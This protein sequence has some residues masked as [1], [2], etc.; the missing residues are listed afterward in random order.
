MRP[1]EG[2]RVLDFSRHFAGA[3]GSRIL[4]NFGAEVL[5]VEWPEPPGLDFLRHMGPADG[6]EGI[7]RSGMFNDINV[8]KRSMTLNMG[9]AEGRDIA[10]ELVKISNVIFESMT[11]GVMKAW[12]LDYETVRQLRPDIVYVSCSGFGQTGPKANWR[13]YGI[14]SAAHAG[15]AHLA[16]LP[17]R[18]PAG[19][20]FQIGD[21]YAMMNAAM[22]LMAG[23]HYQRETGKSVFIDAPQT[24]GVITT[25]NQFVLDN[26]VNGTKTRRPD[27]P[28]GNKRLHP[29]VAPHDAFPCLGTDTWCVIAVYT[30]KEW[31]GLKVA[32]GNP[33]WAE[34]STY[35]TA[36]GRHENQGSLDE[37]LAGWTRGIERHALARL[38]QSH[39]VRAG[40]VQTV[41]DRLNW[42]RQ[43]EH[44]GTYAIFEHP[45]TGP[46]RHETVAAK[47]SKTPYEMRAAAPQ[48]GQDNDYVF[49]GLLKMSDD[50]IE[51]LK[52][53]DVIR[54]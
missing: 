35:R 42:D 50:D 49:R 47:L 24:Q 46:R 54:M 32:M 22:W 11:P 9:T 31:A 39:G 26:S 13:S 23:I 10:R 3:G 18:P 37:Q 38:L 27:F 1:L 15:T 29:Q 16:G 45:E 14:P 7:N 51:R 4:A 40:V 21:S 44:R 20:Q 8:D 12:G 25:G 43:L 36:K 6:I 5:R 48:I 41:Q 28:P 17:G 30:E 19:W 53:D 33:K 34:A 52:A 2:I